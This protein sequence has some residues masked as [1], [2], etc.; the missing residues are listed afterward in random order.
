MAELLLGALEP[1][2]PERAHVRAQ[3]RAAPGGEGRHLIVAARGGVACPGMLRE[4]HVFRRRLYHPHVPV[5]QHVE[6]VRLREGRVPVGHGRQP[7]EAGRRG[8]QA[9]RARGPCR[10]C[11]GG[12]ILRVHQGDKGGAAGARCPAGVV[13]QACPEEGCRRGLAAAQHQGT[14]QRARR[15]EAADR[16]PRGGA[17]DV[18]LDQ[19]C[20]SP[21]TQPPGLASLPAE[22][23][24]PLG[25]VGARRALLKVQEHHEV[26]LEVH[27]PAERVG[28][29]HGVERARRGGAR[30]RPDLQPGRTGQ[31][32]RGAPE[33]HG[34]AA[35]VHL[36]EA[37]LRHGLREL[38][39]HGLLLGPSW[40]LW[41]LW[42]IEVVLRIVL[43]QGPQRLRGRVEERILQGPG[44]VGGWGPLRDPPDVGH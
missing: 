32:L 17:E 23:G 4:H 8:R 35:A 24:Q 2:R 1:D 21:Q 37:G 40:H 9:G 36:V 43:L 7:R 13:S 31:P 44:V 14:C 25:E 18:V 19:Q 16:Q 3:G 22:L 41:R 6:R 33:R 10:W 11:L 39:G 38:R 26:H 15:E 27:D 12:A 5:G 42:L 20:G 29:A 34:A 28:E 30:P